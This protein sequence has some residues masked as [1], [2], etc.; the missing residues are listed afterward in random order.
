MDASKQ[1]HLQAALQWLENSIKATDYQGSSA[2]YHLWRGWAP[3]Y[4]ETTGYLIET[5]LE[6]HQHLKEEKYRDLALGCA[7]WLLS[8]QGMD[9]GFPGGPIGSGN[10]PQVFDTGQIVFGLIAAYECTEEPVYLDAAERACTWL[11]S[12]QEP[13]GCW[14]KGGLHADYAPSYYARVVWAML[15]ANRY[16]QKTSLAQAT[17]GAYGYFQQQWTSSGSVKNWGFAPNEPA[18]THTLAYTLRGLFESALLLEDEKGTKAVVSALERLQGAYAL[19][20]RLAGAYDLNW[21]GDGRFICLTG[22]CQLS[23]LLQ[24]VGHHVQKGDFSHFSKVLLENALSRQCFFPVK[25]VK[26]ALPG[27]W[28]IWGAYMPFRFPNWGLKF[29]VDALLM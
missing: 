26:G 24:R 6:A 2:Y 3:A 17:L 23:I 14:K 25:G 10:P 11:V 5:L 1:K 7:H 16:L 28:P 22:H 20:N 19:K 18:L 8:I 12:L 27:S 13:S 9:G 4:P 29:L 15:R 21:Q